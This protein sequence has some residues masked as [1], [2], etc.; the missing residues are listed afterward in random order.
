MLKRDVEVDII[1][2][3]QCIVTDNVSHGWKGA[4]SKFLYVY[5]CL[6]SNTHVRLSFDEFTMS[7]LHTLNVA[8]T[9]LHPNSWDSV[10]VFCLV[11]ESFSLLPSPKVFLHYYNARP[12]IPIG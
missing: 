1:S 2:L 11:C 12:T 6:F 4:S 5:N 7:V 8:S 10:Q 9:Q 3:E